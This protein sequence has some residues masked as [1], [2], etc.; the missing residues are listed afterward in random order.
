MHWK[1]PRVSEPAGASRPAEA[2]LKVVDPVENLHETRT[3]AG[4]VRRLGEAYG[5]SPAIDDDGVVLTYRELVDRS[6]EL[7]RGL[8]LHRGIGKGSR[9]ALIFANGAD[10]AVALAAVTRIPAPSPFR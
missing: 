6:G 10:F 4:F 3:L 7:A 8:P 1:V 9:V 5:D 2:G